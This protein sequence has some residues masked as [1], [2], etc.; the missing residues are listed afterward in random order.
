MLYYIALLKLL[1]QHVCVGRSEALPFELPV[2][3]THSEL[4]REV[5]CSV[6]RMRE[7]ESVQSLTLVHL[8]NL[9]KVGQRLA[10]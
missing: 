3:L 9:R 4:A 6:R 1:V 2:V 8:D 7:P 10:A 5:L